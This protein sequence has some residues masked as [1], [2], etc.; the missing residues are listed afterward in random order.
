MVYNYRRHS[1]P[2]LRSHFDA[3]LDWMEGVAADKHEA[4]E[5]LRDRME[6]DS[7]DPPHI[8]EVSNARRASEEAEALADRFVDRWAD[9]LLTE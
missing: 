4:L 6:L 5:R 7:D 3:V 2:M 9:R 8:R 1:R